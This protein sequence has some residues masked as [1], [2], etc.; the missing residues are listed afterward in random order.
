MLRPGLPFRQPRPRLHK[1][2]EFANPELP[3]CP[4]GSQQAWRDSCQTT[5]L[6]QVQAAK[7]EEGALPEVIERVGIA[8]GQANADGRGPGDRCGKP[9]VEEEGLPRADGRQG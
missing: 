5:S 7:A 4:G 6:Q 1:C 8:G 3:Q 9:D 2:G